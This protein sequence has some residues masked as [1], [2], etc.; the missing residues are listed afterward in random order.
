MLIGSTSRDDLEQL[1]QGGERRA[2]ESGAE[3][4][5]EIVLFEL[6]DRHILD[7]PLAVRGPG[8]LVVMADDEPDCRG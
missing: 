7:F 4:D 8:D 2:R 1:V 3:L 5:A 6:F